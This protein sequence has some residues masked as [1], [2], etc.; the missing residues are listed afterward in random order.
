MLKSLLT[1]AIAALSFSAAHAAP[2][3]FQYNYGPAVDGF[4]V[5]TISFDFDGTLLGDGNTVLVNSV[6]EIVVNVGTFGII[7]VQSA[8]F[9]QNTVENL[10]GGAYVT[11]DNSA[12]DLFLRPTVPAVFFFDTEGPMTARV[13]TEIGTSLTTSAGLFSIGGSAADEFVAANASVAPA[14]VPLPAG[15]PLLIAG[16]GGLAMLRRRR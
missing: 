3:T 9:A 15:A 12:I 6:T 5:S 8:S 13:N 10:T 16:L 4:G 14:A 11:L 2:F 7:E 1:A